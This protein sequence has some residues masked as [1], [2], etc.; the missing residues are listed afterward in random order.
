M[1]R[2]SVRSVTIPLKG[3]P[4]SFNGFKIAQISDLHV[5]PMIGRDYTQS[6]VNLTNS[7][8]PDLIA[9]T[10]DF[11]D[12]SVAQLAEDVAPLADLRSVHGSFYITGN[13]EYYWG[14]EDWMAEFKRLG[15][16][17]MVNEHERISRGDDHIVLAGIPDLSTLR[18][19][20]IE[21]ADAEKSLLGVAD[22]VVK[23]LLAHQP[24]SYEMAYKAGVDLQLSGHTHA[25]QFFPFSP[26]IRFFQRYYQGLNRHDSMWIYVNSGTGYWGP[27][28]RTGVPSE[29]TLITLVPDLDTAV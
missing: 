4:Q 27:P 7:L 14:A 26:L 3:L 5:G 24:N 11:V 8:N 12:G 10:G 19:Q 22:G 2:P 23:I 15:A 18:N 9:L 28:L 16:R 1:A 6:V 17:V 29:I 21:S 13:H 20:N 25:G